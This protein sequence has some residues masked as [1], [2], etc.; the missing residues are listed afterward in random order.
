MSGGK[1]PSLFTS[2]PQLRDRCASDLRRAGELQMIRFSWVAVV[3]AAGLILS[4]PL[5]GNARADI[6]IDVDKSSQRMSVIVDGAHRYT[7]AVSTGVHGTPS[8]NY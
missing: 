3:A 8:G 4:M 6:V 1:L 5:A 7:W 2:R